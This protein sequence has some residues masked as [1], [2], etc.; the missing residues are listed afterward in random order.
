MEV[1]PAIIAKDI[2]E[3]EEKIRKVET[4][5][6]WV[7]LDIMDGNFVPNTTWNNPEELNAQDF[8][9]FLE[10]HLMILSPQDKIDSWIASGIK[11]IIVHIETVGAERSHTKTDPL[12][13]QVVDMAEKIH[14]AGAQ[15]GLALS[16]ET[17]LSAIE[18]FLDY[19]N[20][21]LVLAVSPGFGGQEF[22]EEVLPKIRELQKTAPQ[23]KIAVDGGINPET[24]RRCV[25]AGADILVAGS[26][27]FN[28]ENIQEAIEELQKLTPKILNS[29][30]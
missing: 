2:K 18:N 14:S 9:V 3:V 20:I 23:V 21:V 4:L 25:E 26:Y 6:T 27:I 7:Q 16:P 1:I 29:K 12:R 17:P 22:K 13:H 28:S 24:G 5:V 15:F 30:F 10:A 19:C 11:R 8:S